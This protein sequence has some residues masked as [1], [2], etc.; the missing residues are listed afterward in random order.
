MA[1]CK[2]ALQRVGKQSGLSRLLR[3]HNSSNLAI[4]AC[5]LTK[6]QVPKQLSSCKLRALSE[7]TNWKTPLTSPNAPPFSILHSNHSCTFHT[8][9][10]GRRQPRTSHGGENSTTRN[11]RTEAANFELD[12]PTSEFRY[13]ATCTPG[14]EKIVAEELA[15]PLIDA[16]NVSPARAGV[17]FMGD[18]AVGYRANLWLRCA[19]RV[20]IHMAEGELVP[21]RPAG[22]EVYDFIRGAVDWQALLLVGGR[23]GARRFKES[24]LRTF[25][26][27]ARVWDCSNVTHSGMVSVRAKD[28]ICDA[29]RD[30]CQG[31]KPPPPENGAN[32]ADLP[33]FLTLYRD[34]ATLYRD[35]SGVS[36][37]KRG[38]RDAMHRASLNEGVAAGMLKLAGFGAGGF[39]A[40]RKGAES[41]GAGASPERGSGRRDNYDPEDGGESRQGVTL[42]DHNM[43]SAAT[44]DGGLTS[45][46]LEVPDGNGRRLES[47]AEASASGRGDADEAQGGAD[48]AQVLL[49]PMCGSGTLLIEAALMAANTA[50]GL[51]R[52][53]WPFESWPDFDE[54]LW[55]QC[56]RD[57]RSHQTDWP[58]GL[59]LLGNDIHPGALELCRKDATAAR[60]IDAITLSQ[61]DCVRYVP[62]A[63]PT[64]VVVNPPW[65]LRLETLDREAQEDEHY[66]LASAYQKLGAFLKDQCTGADVFLLS[67]N[68]DATRNMRLR[69]DR[70]WPLSVGGIDCRVLHYKVLPPLS[71]EGRRAIA[72]DKEARRQGGS[73]EGGSK[74]GRKEGGARY[75]VREG[76]PLEDSIKGRNTG[77]RGGGVKFDWRDD[78]DVEKAERSERDRESK[79]SV[80]S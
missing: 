64:H 28:A 22:D 57:A 49:D 54:Q 77:G 39:R 12:A 10:G 76:R 3:P 72:E 68:A 60:M 6:S 62:P 41:G 48:V 73:Q 11:V 34:K 35:M 29:I 65:G 58:Q 21:W 52:R 5:P 59:R 55:R 70:K 32:D 66:M 42:A 25:W 51:L 71:E 40:K 45:A 19:V 30:T 1:A 61:E 18:L 4:K 16:Q 7:E 26:V 9:L 80:W 23:N 17:A 75:G 74:S 8:A 56:V 53:R 24:Q 38:Y 2:T 36:L 37:H 46:A 31:L 13:F 33:L 43:S 79:T 50:P 47:H 67:G 44:A 78:V 14:L 20:L 27:D 15:S 69:A 63:K